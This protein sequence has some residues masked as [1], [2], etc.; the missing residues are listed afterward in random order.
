MT[1]VFDVYGGRS[2]DKY[3]VQKSG[4]LSNLEFNDDVMTDKGFQ[5]ETELLFKYCNLAAPPGAR[6]KLQ[7]THGEAMKTKTI[8]NL[9]IHVERAIRRI[10]TF[11][12]LSK[13][14]LPVTMF[15]HLND[16]VRSCAALCN[17]QN[18]YV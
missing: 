9:R 5:I 12:I 11:Q 2:S 3:I 4:F 17:L 1:F 6:L 14:N 7:F 10:K 13:L 8:A 16:I 18:V 15:H